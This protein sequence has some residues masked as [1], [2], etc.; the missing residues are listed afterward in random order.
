[1]PM[2][3]E[4]AREKRMRI[5]AEQGRVFVPKK[6]TGIDCSDK[7]EYKREYKRIQRRKAGARLRADMTAKTQAK[8]EAA[9]IKAAIRLQQQKDAPHDAHVKRYAKAISD[10]AKYAKRY[11]ANPQAERQRTAQRKQLLPDAYVI[12]QLKS[13][14]IPREI[15]TPELIDLKR[16]CIQYRRL[17]RNIKSTVKNHLKEQNETITKHP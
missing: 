3:P 13:C 10:R 6:P 12:Q 9:A 8:R 16:D 4:K 2:S 14:G 5:A 1:M 15:V 17:S 11:K 7:A